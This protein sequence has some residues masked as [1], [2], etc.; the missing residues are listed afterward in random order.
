MDGLIFFRKPL[1]G[2]ILFLAA[3]G[4]RHDA[5]RAD[6]TDSFDIAVSDLLPSD[7]GNSYFGG[8]ARGSPKGPLLVCPLRGGSLHQN[9][10]CL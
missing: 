4:Y 10:A 8:V 6:P 9:S 3:V 5:R 1:V 7:L 2:L